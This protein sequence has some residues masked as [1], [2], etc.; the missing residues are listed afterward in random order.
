M[1]ARPSKRVALRLHALLDSGLVEAR[2]IAAWAEFRLAG[3]DDPDPLLREIAGLVEAKALARRLRDHAFAP[4]LEE[5]DWREVD[6][7]HLAALLLRHRRLELTWAEFLN[8]AGLCADA[9][10]RE[11]AREELDAMLT[12]IENARFPD[13]LA[14]RQRRELEERL[15]SATARIR[16]LFE[17]L[18]RPP[19]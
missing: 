3:S 18:R 4:S 14:K 15:E 8:R 9:A 1:S 11:W 12:A 6:D 16:P 2:E 7:E 17:S 10:N 19:A 5:F 13:R